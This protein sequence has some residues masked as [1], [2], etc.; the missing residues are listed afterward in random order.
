MKVNRNL[1]NREHRR[2]TVEAEETG[3]NHE[4]EQDP[5]KSDCD[6][7]AEQIRSMRQE[8][9]DL[10]TL[11]STRTRELRD[12]Q[13]NRPVIDATSLAD[14][15][16]M[17][18]RLNAESF[19]L[20]ASLADTFTFLASHKDHD[21]ARELRKKISP[22]LVGL[23]Q[24]ARHDTDPFC[25]QMILQSYISS[26]AAEC[27]TRWFFDPLDTHNTLL[28]SLYGNVQSHGKTENIMESQV[29]SRP[30]H[31]PENLSSSWRWRAVAYRALRETNEVEDAEP[32][33]SAITQTLTEIL[34]TAGVQGKDQ[35]VADE[36]ASATR[37][38]LVDIIKLIP[39]LRKAIFEDVVSCALRITFPPSDTPYD[40]NHMEALEDAEET[41]KTDQR[42]LYTTDLGLRREVTSHGT[43]EEE[44]EGSIL[45]AKVVLESMIKE[46]FRAGQN[47]AHEGEPFRV[48]ASIHSPLE[49]AVRPTDAR[50]EVGEGMVTQVGTRDENRTDL[51]ETY[52]GLS[53]RDHTCFVLRQ[54]YYFLECTLVFE[55]IVVVV[56]NR[57]GGRS[58]TI[59]RGVTRTSHFNARFVR[60]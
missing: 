58:V 54:S 40:G 3:S 60:A 52:K 21:S 48:T 42:V 20:S 57:C 34:Y 6:V 4:D 31:V 7:M 13:T 27:S 11:L 16:R 14:V 50:V 53:H 25:V 45:K 56:S 15:R 59:P 18:E 38:K 22:R 30:C 12:A 44:E 51:E 49:Q 24:A 41:V 33:I 29:C 26:A 47:P 35:D 37:E 36:V 9:L 55:M 32:V 19:Q 23:L 43:T 10:R 5:Q 39:P 2:L 46:H 1:F 8:L 17:V 28:Q